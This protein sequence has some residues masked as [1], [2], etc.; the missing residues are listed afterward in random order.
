MDHLFDFF[1]YALCGYIMSTIA[2]PFTGLWFI[3][4]VIFLFVAI[5]LDRPSEYLNR[6]KK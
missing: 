5:K 1:I 2:A 3:L 4:F 6:I